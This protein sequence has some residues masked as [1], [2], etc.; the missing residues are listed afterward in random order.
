MDEKQ[1]EH[2]RKLCRK[3]K[4][5]DSTVPGKFASIASFDCL[6]FFCCKAIT[7][8]SGASE[9]PAWKIIFLDATRVHCQA[10][11]MRERTVELPQEEQVIIEMNLE[12]G[13]W[14][15]AIVCCCERID[16][17]RRDH[18]IFVG[19][20]MHTAWVDFEAWTES[21]LNEEKDLRRKAVLVLYDYKDYNEGDMVMAVPSHQASEI[22]T[23][24]EFLRETEINHQ[25]RRI[26][27]HSECRR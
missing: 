10:D 18:F 24:S 11:A 12:I 26:E 3:D 21:Q 17:I 25:D 4:R 15:S 9:T 16:R 14:S 13:M 27:I 20:S 19:E 23:H 6:M 7:W 1:P 2:R 8:R 5:W 22:E